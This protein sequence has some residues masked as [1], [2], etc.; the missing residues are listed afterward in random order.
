MTL[1]ILTHCSL[2]TILSILPTALMGNNINWQEFLVNTLTG[3]K[4]IPEPYLMG[5]S[6]NK[7]MSF[8][9]HYIM[10]RLK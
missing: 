2:Q 5:V 10:S 9:H 7:L 3:S 1:A 6:V 8:I 4:T